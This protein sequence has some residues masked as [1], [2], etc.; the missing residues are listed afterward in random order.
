MYCNIFKL[1][2]GASMIRFVGRSVCG[3]NWMNKPKTFVNLTPINHGAC[4]S[5]ILPYL[6]KQKQPLDKYEDTRIKYR[7]ENKFYLTQW[8]NLKNV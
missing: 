6:V 7:T 1:R 2:Q 3:K 5:P 4:F 8:V